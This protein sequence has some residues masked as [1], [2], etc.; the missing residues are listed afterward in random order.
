MEK[1][2]IYDI[3]SLSISPEEGLFV[4]NDVFKSP[5]HPDEENIPSGGYYYSLQQFFPSLEE[6]EKTGKN[7]QMRIVRALEVDKVAEADPYE[8]ISL[9]KYAEKDIRIDVYPAL[10]TVARVGNTTG[11]IQ[12]NNDFFKLPPKLRDFITLQLMHLFKTKRTD[13]NDSIQAFVESDSKA[14]DRVNELYPSFGNDYEWLSG[15]FRELPPMM[16]N[17]AR[18]QNIN[19]LIFN[20]KAENIIY[21]HSETRFSL[22]DRIMLLFGKPFFM[23]TEIYVDKPVNVASSKTKTTTKV[24]NPK[25]KS[26]KYE[27]AYS[28]KVI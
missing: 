14:F 15:Y 17:S 3:V 5:H 20:K 10:D 9:L 4:I 8:H 16:M 11:I 27:V 26:L 2:N 22:K 6:F 28:D 13:F 18:N 23:T 25:Q 21:T 19:H 7:L 1:L 12:V 24:G